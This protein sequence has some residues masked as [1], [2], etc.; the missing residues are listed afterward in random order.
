[1][2]PPRFYKSLINSAAGLFGARV[3]AAD[4]GPRGVHATLT[5][6]Q[7]RGFAPAVIFDI[8]ASNGQWTRMCRSIFPESQYVLAEPLE[9]H[10][11]ELQAM[12]HADQRV[13]VWCGVAGAAP[14]TVQL[15]DHGD[16][17]SLLQSK[18][19]PGRPTSV[20]STTVDALLASHGA[21]APVLL[22]A[23]V[24][25][26]ELEV[27][28][29]ASRCLEQ[30]EMLILEVSFRRIYKDNPLAHEIV[31]Y[32]GERGFQIYDV[33]SY[34][35]RASDRELIQSDFVFVHESSA[36]LNGEGWT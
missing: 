13:S 30:A 16:Q 22:K 1:M 33:C 18:D 3:V 6:A 21:A 8:G 12:A 34:L 36:L 20:Q 25:G 28:K 4:W 11:E 32:V 7:G 23:D 2:S 9:A 27:L 10:R 5:R 35:Q 15:Y 19:F 26:Y 17:S 29:G 31:A 24:Q 14:G